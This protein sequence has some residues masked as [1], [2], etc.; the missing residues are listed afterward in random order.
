M[1]ERGAQ[2]EDRPAWLEKL[3]TMKP[4]AV[5]SELENR[6]ADWKEEAAALEDRFAARSAEGQAAVREKLDEARAEM[7]EIEERLEALR[8]AGEEQAEEAKGRLTALAIGLR[9]DLDR[10][11]ERLGSSNT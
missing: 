3:E 2:H 5:I 1:N 4:S 11:K 6:M 10:V 7:D 9:R 8:D